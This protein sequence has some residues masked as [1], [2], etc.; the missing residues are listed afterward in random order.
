MHKPR[1]RRLDWVYTDNPVYFVTACTNARRHLLD[2]ERAHSVFRCFCE[3]G[4][5]RGVWVGR[6]VLM[7]DHIHLFVAV[8]SNGP[9]LSE[10]MKAL[11][12]TMNSAF[13]QASQPDPFWQKGFFDRVLRSEE[14]Y[15]KKW[16]YVR[17]NPVRAGLVSR[18]EDWLYQGEI[19][20]LT[21]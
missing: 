14:S 2:N 6:Y 17:L 16:E 12:R 7:P 1:L 8:A 9:S 11:K 13:A 4:V 3:E 18:A 19:N 5:P 15:A 20:P 21:L 10:W